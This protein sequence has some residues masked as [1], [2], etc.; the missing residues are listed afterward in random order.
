MFLRLRVC[1]LMSVLWTEND[2]IPSA[3]RLFLRC[4]FGRATKQRRSEAFVMVHL[5]TMG[6][7]AFVCMDTC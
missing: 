1:F 2:S 4:R 6:S 5:S 3:A 7:S